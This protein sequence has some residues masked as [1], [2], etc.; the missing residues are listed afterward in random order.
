M[1]IDDKSRGLRLVGDGFEIELPS[2]PDL[3][4]AVAESVA[5]MGSFTGPADAAMKALAMRMAQEIEETA[6]RAVL[7]KRA[8]ELA[9]GDDEVWKILNRLEAMCNLTRTVAL[10]GPQLQAVLRDLGGAPAARKA[11]SKEGRTGGRLAQLRDA[12][13]QD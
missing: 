1:T 7:H 4:V 2:T 12:S 6:E 11:L 3:R 5:G 10:L 8:G 13:G 9:A